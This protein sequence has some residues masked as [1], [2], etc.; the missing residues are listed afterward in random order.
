MA[1]FKVITSM[2]TDVEN[3]LIKHAC[4]S[5]PEPTGCTEGI[6]KWWHPIGNKI[7]TNN[8]SGLIC[9]GLIPQCQAFQP[10]TNIILSLNNCDV[11]KNDLDHLAK[12]I[13][14]DEASKVVIEMLSGKMFCQDPEMG[15]K[16]EDV[17]LCQQ[18][19]AA[20]M[21]TSLKLIFDYFA[22]NGQVVCHGVFHNCDVK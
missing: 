1:L 11:C 8:S 17:K 19:I 13:G 18:Y 4:G 5:M 15:L 3:F 7:F 10:P 22:M 9:N 21:P 16:D 6:K 2:E 12:L 14:S 20:F